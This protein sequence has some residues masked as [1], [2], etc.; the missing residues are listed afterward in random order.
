[1]GEIPIYHLGSLLAGADLSTKQYFAVKVNASG[2][3]V[4]CGA[5]EPCAGILQNA[6]ESGFVASVM[7][8]GT[9]F[10]ELGDS[11]TAG[12]NVMSD[13]AGKIVPHTGTNEI[14]GL[15]VASGSSGEQID[16]S[17]APGSGAGKSAVNSTFVFPVALA[18]I[19]DADVVTDFIPGFA[20][21]IQKV[22]FIVGTPVTTASKATTLN[23][24]IET[25]NV[26]GGVVALTSANATPLG[27]VIEGTAVTANN[28]FTD[29]EKISIEATSTT[30]F[31]EG[32]G[33]IV[34]TYSTN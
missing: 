24:E 31:A 29:S 13:S 17:L 11:V 1:M 10:A 7:R 20:G 4:L 19:T 14:V 12:T 9:S 34:I 3:I 16:I 28:V 30:A 33:T 23:V 32:T 25:T 5:G 15:A 6:P 2:L 27:K 26:T 22:Q 21:T 18:D 8:V